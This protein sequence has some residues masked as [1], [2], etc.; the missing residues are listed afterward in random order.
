MASGKVLPPSMTI[1]LPVV[2]LR[3]FLGR[4]GV[5]RLRV[6]CQTFHW[7][8]YCDVLD[9]TFSG[10]S[11]LVQWPSF[12]PLACAHIP[13][14]SNSCNMTV[15]IRQPSISLNQR[16]LLLSWCSYLH[17][18]ICYDIPWQMRQWRCYPALFQHIRDDR[19]TSYSY[20]F[21]IHVN[22]EV[23]AFHQLI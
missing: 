20:T 22:M 23:S 9:G 16:A 11:G 8:A 2:R 14:V 6:E 17:C 4:R 3:H 19:L 10:L 5:R 18:D 13:V 12:Q 1:W 21:D 15:C 7:H